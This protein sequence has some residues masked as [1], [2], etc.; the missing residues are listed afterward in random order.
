ME[1][2]VSLRELKE[3]DQKEL[4]NIEGGLLPKCLRGEDYNVVLSVLLGPGIGTCYDIG[5]VLGRI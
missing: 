3:L 2:M 5:Y 4:K 1:K